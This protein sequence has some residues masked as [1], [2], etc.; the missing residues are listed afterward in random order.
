MT[1]YCKGCGVKLQNEDPK[2]LGYVPNADAEYCQRCFKIRNY[3]DVVISMQKGIESS[4]TFDKI[5]Q[6]D[7]VVFWIV[8]LFTFESSIIPNLNEKLPGKDIILV[9]TKRDVLPKT[10]TNQKIAQFVQERL[11]HENIHVKDILVCG[12]LLKDSE[13]SRMYINFINEAIDYYRNGRDVIFMGIANVGKSTIL[14]HLNQNKELTTSRNPGTTL[15]LVSIQKDGYV[16]YDTPG[17]ENY[18]SVLT[19]LPVQD[20]K[21]VIPTKPIRPFISQIYEDQSFA[22]GGLARLDVKVKGRATVVGYFSRAL[23][24]HRGKL[25][26]A[27]ALW[28]NHLNELLSPSLDTSMDTMKTLQCKMKG[29]KMDVVIHGVGWFCISGDIKEVKVKVHNGI[30][31]TFRKAMI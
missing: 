30:Y 19:H 17:I 14:N 4:Q 13:E 6:I 16:I 5:N 12:Y 15:D 27:D 23:S 11:E 8:D 22:V 29:D 10:L 28:E 26:K 18:H 21:T 24:I 20:L 9:L 3:G 31:V 25:E 2:K 1:T 7:G